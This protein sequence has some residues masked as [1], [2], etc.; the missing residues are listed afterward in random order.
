GCIYGYDNITVRQINK[1]HTQG[2][3]TAYQQK[4]R[5]VRRYLEGA[6]LYEA[7]TYS[8]TSPYRSKRFSMYDVEKEAVRLALPMSEERSELRLSLL[9]HLLE[10]TSYNIAR[11]NEDVALYEIGSIFIPNEQDELPIEIAHLAGV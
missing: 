5:K 2:T 11:K 9:P 8:L 6:G 4:R 7:R 1:K 10:S 3:L